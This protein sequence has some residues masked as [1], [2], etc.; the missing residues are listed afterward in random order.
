M[1]TRLAADG[2]LIIYFSANFDR[3][4][5]W[6]Q[7]LAV[8]HHGAL[9]PPRATDKWTLAEL[10]AAAVSGKTGLASLL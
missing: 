10:T 2:K 5:R 3:Q 1:M 6:T 7:T 4:L 8:F 9:L